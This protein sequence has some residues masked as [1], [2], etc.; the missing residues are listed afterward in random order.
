MGVMLITGAPTL[1][2][3]NYHE[4]YPIASIAAVAA[5]ALLMATPAAPDSKWAVGLGVACAIAVC[6]H[7]GYIW[8]F[9]AA[10][11]A[12]WDRTARL[13]PPAFVVGAGTATI[14]LVLAAFRLAGWDLRWGNAAGGM[15]GPLVTQL[16]GPHRGEELAIIATVVIAGALPLVILGAA[17]R[18]AGQCRRDAIVLACGPVVFWLL[19]GFDYGFPLDLDAATSAVWGV[20]PLAIIGAIRL[21]DR[22]RVL[23]AGLVTVV[24]TS[25]LLSSYVMPVVDYPDEPRIVV[26]EVSS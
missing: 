6:F 14:G 4:M 20:L 12:V 8:L 11:F 3:G 2:V 15:G 21:A 18:R 22:G 25:V 5:I 26:P 10:C 24:S 17:T 7:G 13:G 16:F 23:L 1:F 9:M 19:W